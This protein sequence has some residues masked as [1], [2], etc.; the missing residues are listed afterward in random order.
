MNVH[1]MPNAGISANPAASV[2]AMAP[3]VFVRYNNPTLG[4]IGPPRPSADRTTSDSEAP[5][6][7]V[8]SS[9]SAAS[10]R[11]TICSGCTAAGPEKM[12]AFVG[13]GPILTDDRPLV[14]YFLSMPRDRDPDLSRL[15]GDVKR[16]VADD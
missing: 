6:S 12:R 16:H 3:A 7:I 13:D 9:G 11:S 14:E 8:P 10:G 2:P 15:R 4:A 5:M 1:R